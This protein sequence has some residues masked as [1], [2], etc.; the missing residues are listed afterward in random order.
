MGKER[1][2]FET[3]P[4][5]QIGK[6]ELFKEGH[7]HIVVNNDNSV[8]LYTHEYGP[9]R[10]LSIEDVNED[11]DDPSWRATS[12]SFSSP[13]ATSFEIYSDTMQEVWLRHIRQN[14]W[15]TLSPMWVPFFGSNKIKGVSSFPSTDGALIFDP[16][17]S[18]ITVLKGSALQSLPLLPLMLMVA[19][20]L[21]GS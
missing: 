8:M 14:K 17:L 3:F 20:T 11:S 12:S 16:P 13:W 2:G 9:S 21:V 5:E 1:V 19:A 6:R 10:F 4:P 15:I 7:W 18:N